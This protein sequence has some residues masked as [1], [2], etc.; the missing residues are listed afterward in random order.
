MSAFLL[1]VF[2]KA[3]VPG[4]V[5]TR[6]AAEIGEQEATAAYRRIV[7]TLMG[8]IGGTGNI[9][10]TYAPEGGGP[11]ITDW[12]GSHYSYAPQTNGDLGSRMSNAFQQAFDAGSKKVLLIGSDCP[13]I[14]MSDLDAATLALDANDVVIGPANDG[15]Y[16][17]I[18]MK[19]PHPDLFTDIPWSTESV[20]ERTMQICLNSN[21][22]VHQLAR[23]TD[24]DSAAEWE[25]FVKSKKNVKGSRKQ[26]IV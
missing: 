18:G 10:L 3:P 8:E 26:P 5:K 12:L 24:I 23:K 4:N 1:I 9:A 20:L 6:L 2:V 15:G 17:L 7:E 14:A 13:Y 21:L 25:E 16:W 19:S 22:T 11:M